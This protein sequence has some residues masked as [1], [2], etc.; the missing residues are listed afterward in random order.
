M[1]Y[2][3]IKELNGTFDE[4]N[5]YVDNLQLSGSCAG[6]QELLLLKHVM[7]LKKYNKLKIKLSERAILSQVKAYTAGIMTSKDKIVFLDCVQRLKKRYKKNNQEKMEKLMKET[8]KQIK[9][10]LS[11][12]KSKKTPWL[13]GTIKE[14]SIFADE[15][16][17]CFIKGLRAIQKM[18]LKLAKKKIAKFFKLK[19]MNFSS[20]LPENVEA[21]KI[22]AKAFSEFSKKKKNNE[23]SLAQLNLILG[24][25]CN[26]YKLLQEEEFKK[27]DN[28]IKILY[29]ESFKEL[30]KFVTSKYK[31]H[32]FIKS[33]ALP[34][35]ENWENIFNKLKEVDT[36]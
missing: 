25:C 28:D 2:E 3:G 16:L 35:K 21:I 4:E 34:W 9:G 27:F 31:K 11:N 8:A 33:K 20:N 18:D 10:S 6:R 17:Q 7:D 36:L 12:Q 15:R 13:F 32:N 22:I 26:G 24:L 5:S 30:F 23:F 14:P 19:A 29:I 1:L